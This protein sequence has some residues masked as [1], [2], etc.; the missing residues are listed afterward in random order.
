MGFRGS[1]PGERRGGRQKGTP[2]KVS[3]DIRDMVI[4]AL[5]KAGGLDYLAR[6]AEENP[7]AFLTLVGKVLPTTL[8]GD[9]NEPVRHIFEW[10]KPGEDDG[11]KA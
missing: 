11:E 5:N 8:T 6:Q 2:N 9:A 4:R 10:A 7:G 3:A 1:A